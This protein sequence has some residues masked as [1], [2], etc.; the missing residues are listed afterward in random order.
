MLCKHGTSSTVVQ[1]SDDSWWGEY[2]WNGIMV[3]CQPTAVIT[4]C[5][6]W[7]LCEFPGEATCEKKTCTLTLSMVELTVG[8]LLW[9]VPAKLVEL[10]YGIKKLTIICVIEDDKISV[11]DLREEIEQFEDLVSS[12]SVLVCV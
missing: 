1:L 9:C 8:P 7:T 12:L 4:V 6:L 5:I 3:Y 10:A 11:E 2:K